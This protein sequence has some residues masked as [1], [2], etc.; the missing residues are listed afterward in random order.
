MECATIDVVRT[1]T[2]RE[3]VRLLRGVR[4]AD[5]PGRT[6]L[7]AVYAGGGTGLHAPWPPASGLA[8][9]VPRDDGWLRLDLR[10]VMIISAWQ[11]AAAADRYEDRHRFPR[12][13]EHWRVRMR[14]IRGGTSAHVRPG[15]AG[16]VRR[17][18]HPVRRAPRGTPE[19][20]H[21]RAWFGRFVVEG[22]EG[23]IA[24]QDPFAGLTDASIRSG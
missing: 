14:P 5:I 4:A 3:A 11:D 10:R 2:R 7:G 1:R 23:T 19:E 24:G 20:L 6:L 18:A 15:A 22:S 8:R 13:T 12:P 17:R 16:V 9:L 21:S